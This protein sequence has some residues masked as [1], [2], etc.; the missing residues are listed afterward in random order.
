MVSASDAML[1]DVANGHGRLG[2]GDTVALC[3]CLAS[4]G[5][6]LSGLPSQPGQWLVTLRVDLTKIRGLGGVQTTLSSFRP[7]VN[8]HFDTFCTSS[9]YG[10]CL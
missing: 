5:F 2:F 8:E 7:L 9:C 6:A 3:W 1:G 10:V 4:L